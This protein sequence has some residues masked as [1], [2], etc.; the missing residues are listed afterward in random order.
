MT[1]PTLYRATFQAPRGL[2]LRRMTFAAASE[3]AA[4]AWA[5]QWAQGRLLLKVQPLRPLQRPIL[6]LEA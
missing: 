6:T 3:A 1:S 2:P 5:A 4:I